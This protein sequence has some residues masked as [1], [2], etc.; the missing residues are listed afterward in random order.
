MT[1]VVHSWTPRSD[2][3]GERVA[4]LFGRG[5]LLVIIDYV[6][7]IWSILILYLVDILRFILK[8]NIN[9]F[10]YR[11]KYTKFIFKIILYSVKKK[12]KKKT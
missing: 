3:D 1:R 11:N 7:L 10:G 6:N 8:K 5:P 12:K 9:M 2:S 4:L